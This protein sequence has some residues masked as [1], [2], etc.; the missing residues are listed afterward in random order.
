M[1][2]NTAVKILISIAS[3]LIIALMYILSGRDTDEPSTA[4]PAKGNL[5]EF[6]VLWGDSY[7]G[8]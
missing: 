1:Q 4:D 6:S 5:T 7:A 3:L 8:T 2:R